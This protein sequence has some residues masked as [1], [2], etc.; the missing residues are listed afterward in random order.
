MD[1][2]H[3]LAK[4]DLKPEVDYAWFDAEMF[5]EGE[6]Y[7]ELFN[8]LVAITKGKLNPQNLTCR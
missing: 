6:S 7:L 4:Y 8:W 5:D 1:P 2:S 3:V